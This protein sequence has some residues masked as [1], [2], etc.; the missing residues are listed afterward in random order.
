MSLTAA[1][2][3]AIVAR[4]NVLVVAGA[5]TGK[6]RTLVERCLHCLIEEKPPTSLD[7][8][9]MV[10]FTEAAAA[11]MR[12]RI[13][14][15]LEEEL[16]KEPGNSRWQEQL[17]LFESAHIGT[18][19]SFCLKIVRQHFYELELDPQLSV[20][21]DE[22]ARLLAE[23]TLD[24]LLR[25]HY[26]GRTKI[27]GAVQD[28]IQTQG[29]GRDKT[30]RALVMRLH[31]Y[32]QT[33][34]SPASWTREQLALFG[35]AQPASWR[36]WLRAALGEWRQQWLPAL[37]ALAGNDPAAACATA[38]KGLDPERE[39]AAGVLEAI[40]RAP[41]DCPRGQKTAW[42]KPLKR[43]FEE[44]EFFHS[45]TRK[46]GSADPLVEDWTWVRGQMATLIRLAAE[47]TESFTEAKRELGV[48]D[49]QDLEQ[50]TLRLLWDP[51]AGLPTGTA[52]HWRERLRFVFVDEY[53]D[54]NTA[55]DKIIEAL[56][57]TDAGSNRFLVG[58][59]KQSIYRFRLANPRIFQKYADTW[60]GVGGRVVPL[61][62]N[63]RSCEGILN[64]VN[65]VFSL[66][67][68]PEIGGLAYDTRAR[69]R[70]GAPGE[71]DALAAARGSSPRVELLL[72]VKGESDAGDLD[73]EAA[74][75]MARV[76]DLEEADK[77]ARLVGLRLR[78]LQAAEH[79]VWDEGKK[80]FRPV[81]WGDMAI[82]LRSP[83]G[84]AESYA[85]EFSRLGLP[86][87]VVR[88]GFYQS[89]EISDLLS[90]LQ[91]LDNPLQD[92][93]AIAVLRSP[94]VGLSLNELARI[95]LG[96]KGRFWTAL[97]RWEEA[98]SGR[99]EPVRLR[100]EPHPD[101]ETLN[102]VSNFVRHFARWRRL[103]RQVSLSRCLES[104]LSETHYGSWLL[105]QPRG[106]QRQANVQRLLSLAQQ[107]DKFQ[108]QSLFRFL[109]FVEAQRMAETEPEAPAVSAENSIR[110]MSIHQSKG[111]EFPLV[112]LADLAKPF[113]VSDQRAEIILDEVY[114]L[115]P[116]IK[117]PHTGKRYPSLP[118]WLASRRQ[119]RE[120]LGEEL[121][122]LY[123]AMT[124]ARDTLLLAGSIA[125]GKLEKQ[126][127]SGDGDSA[128]A[129]SGARGYADWLGWWFARHCQAGPEAR[130]GENELLRWSIHGD[131][132]LLTP[133]VEAGDAGTPATPRQPDA[134]ASW[135]RLR[136]RLGWSYPFAAATRK[137]AKT[138]VTLLRRRASALMDGETSVLL[139][140]A[141]PEWTAAASRLSRAA[142]ESAA[143]GL[144]LL[145][146][147]EIGIAHHSFLE[148][149]APER[150]GGVA[151]LRREAARL[152]QEGALTAEQARALDFKMLAA[153][154][155]SDLGLKIRAN[156]EALRRE[157]AFT[158][159]ATAAELAG[160][161]GEP[162]EAG[163][164]GE[165]IVVQGV[166]DVALLLPGEIVVLDFKTDAM[167]SSRLG[168]KLGL[169]A[170]Q[171]RL[172]ARAL[173]SIYRRPVSACWLYFLALNQAVSVPLPARPEDPGPK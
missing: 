72:R 54:I 170:P 148:F 104:V 53:Q 158:V 44:A 93:P 131:E 23:E 64:F 157:L 173:S 94:L 50:Y 135:A 168:E 51:A 42:L 139:P 122:L 21:A 159:R 4:G 137:P 120:M 34:P 40:R 11:E 20:L 96:V 79:P 87:L 84:K 150:A 126:W 107:F 156:P 95:R 111:L 47:F 154:W 119:H 105:T 70:F 136:E 171:L 153:F 140:R 113:N 38:L 46:T 43:L 49:F 36:Q 166:V 73:E 8:I 97:L 155:A 83:S 19:H 56:S 32:A 144:A 128:A 71:R 127:R 91:L 124:R 31:R 152:E 164:D 169:Y 110:L 7:Q 129:L 123:V 1:Q 162:L 9:L 45:L 60:D 10:T 125:P 143:P 98:M 151:E 108:R 35:R 149:V 112:A 12:Q 146:A 62:E 59:V 52:L 6:T 121:R 76:A 81:E 132:S 27:A 77:E 106:E 41:S 167:D 74:E 141:T 82:L 48:V 26:E 29:R 145:S 101:L 103:A 90:L 115:C 3:E 18:L 28:L 65:S 16:R 134:A 15:R 67:M 69:L 57:R 172:Y 25:R 92:I 55:Q 117:P 22:E 58:D 80:Q 142:A 2:Q 68:R 99:L 14:L 5:G 37:E 130:E 75:A 89:M 13:R 88:G 160:I 78:E 114:G 138:S 24:G 63:F 85:K 147:A 66:L 61:V 109:R 102:K 39:D 33:L 165:F 86:L 133:A 30:V 100:G 116:Q 161:T 17:A 118:H 163:L